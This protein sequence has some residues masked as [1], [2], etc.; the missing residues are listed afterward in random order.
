MKDRFFFFK[1][2]TCIE[3]D[4]GKPSH[5]PFCVHTLG[6]IKPYFFCLLVKKP[7][8]FFSWFLSFL[9]SLVF[10][11]NKSGILCIILTLLCSLRA[12]QLY[13]SSTRELRSEYGSWLPSNK[14]HT[15]Q[16]LDHLKND[17][18]IIGTNTSNIFYFIHV[19]CGDSPKKKT[20]WYSYFY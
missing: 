11:M 1:F 16:P 14:I 17:S 9:F 6:R 2:Y 20:T 8:F 7:S 19:N 10:L 13:L 3:Q 12:F 4:H 15:Q 5:Q 18:I